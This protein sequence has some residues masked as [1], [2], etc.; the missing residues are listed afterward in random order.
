M[1]HANDFIKWLVSFA[2]IVTTLFISGQTQAA[3]GLGYYRVNKMLYALS[4]RVP[5]ETM[6][7][8]NNDDKPLFIQVKVLQWERKNGKDYYQ[9]TKE[10]ITAPPIIKLAPKSDQVVRIV[11]R[12]PFAAKELMYRLQITDITPLPKVSEQGVLKGAAVVIKMQYL[13]PLYVAPV[14]EQPAITWQLHQMA[15]SAQVAI[16]NAGNVSLRVVKVVLSDP[17]TD[18]VIA[19]TE[20]GA[21]IFVGENHSWSLSLKNGSPSRVKVAAV[22]EN[23]MSITNTIPVN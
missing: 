6:V 22:L 17:T 9:S 15:Q 1:T 7:L 4:P 20:K 21:V 5:V 16:H 12:R 19:A 11:M 3:K 18:R 14:Q 13:L 10:V 23:G 2:L 8:S